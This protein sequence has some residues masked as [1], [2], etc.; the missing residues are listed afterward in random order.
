MSWHSYGITF[1]FWQSNSF[2]KYNQ[3]ACIL[4][5]RYNT[6]PEKAIPSE[7]VHNRKRCISWTK[8][9]FKRSK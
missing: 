6:T 4:A 5:L 3:R 7:E 9:A 8:L 2:S 1:T